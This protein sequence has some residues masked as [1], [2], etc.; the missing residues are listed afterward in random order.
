VLR[1]FGIAVVT[2]ANLLAPRI[3]VMLRAAVADLGVLLYILCAPLL[4]NPPVW[5]EGSGTD[6]SEM[7]GL[8]LAGVGFFILALCVAR[9]NRSPQDYLTGTYLV[10]R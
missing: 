2:G 1:W 7:A 4:F 10:P 9:P 5:T 8:A 3:R 6:I